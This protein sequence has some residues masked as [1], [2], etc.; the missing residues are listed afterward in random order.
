MGNQTVHSFCNFWE[1]ERNGRTVPRSRNRVIPLVM[2][3]NILL[4]ICVEKSE[5]S[6]TVFF[7]AK[8]FG[9][10]GI[11]RRSAAC[12]MRTLF[13]LENLPSLVTFVYVC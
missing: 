3:E 13:C 6:E 12:Q 7:L 4:I 9:V 5:K 10:E 8:S 11:H 1:I 2:K